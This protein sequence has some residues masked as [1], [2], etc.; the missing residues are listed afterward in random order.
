MPGEPGDP[1]EHLQRLH[2]QVRPLRPPRGDQVIYLVAEQRFVED[3][4][5]GVRLRARTGALAHY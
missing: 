2:V 1:A 5:V 4:L 3:L